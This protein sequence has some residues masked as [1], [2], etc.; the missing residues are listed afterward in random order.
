MNRRTYLK[1]SSALLGL[2]FAN[3]SIAKFL[4]TWDDAKVL[5][6]KPILFTDFQ[7]QMVAEI[8]ETICPK[9][10]TPGAKELAVPQ[11][12][13]LMV[14]DVMSPNDQKVFLEGI[15]EV[16][17]KSKN[18]FGKPFL[19]LD[20]SQKESMLIALD[21]ES[22]NFPPTM[23]GIVL[24]EKPDPITFFRRIKSLTLT[25]YFTSEKIG[26]EVLAYDPIPGK[27]V[28]CMPLNGQ[29]AWSE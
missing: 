28:P 19:A 15:Q 27:F 5:E 18:Q 17:E 24:V 22:P 9:T 26:K 8:A 13:E 20:K 12:I 1:N 16:D 21:K 2:T 10:S 3:H 7:A 11:F 14:K 23:W 25:G 6:W 4:K 29:N